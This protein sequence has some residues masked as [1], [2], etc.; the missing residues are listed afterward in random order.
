LLIDTDRL[1]L[2]DCHVATEYGTLDGLQK[3]WEWAKEILKKRGV[4]NR[5]ISPRQRNYL[6]HLAAKCVTK[7]VS[8]IICEWFKENLT[9]EVINILY[10]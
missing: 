6:W 10:C 8:Q 5:S 3:I 2:T 4:K 7:D 9:T 1:G